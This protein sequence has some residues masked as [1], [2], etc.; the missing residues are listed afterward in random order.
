MPPIMC[1]RN[2]SDSHKETG[3]FDE[4]WDKLREETFARQKKLGVIP[5]D[6]QPNGTFPWH[7]GLGTPSQPR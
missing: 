3:Q 1:L 4:G 5:Q 6:C 7:P 2:G